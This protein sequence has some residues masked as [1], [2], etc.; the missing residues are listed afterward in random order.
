MSES[1]EIPLHL[2]YED[3]LAQWRERQP[4]C[5][6]R[7]LREQQ[8]NAERFRVISLPADDG[9]LCGVACGLGKFKCELTLYQAAAIA[10]RVPPLQYR[11]A[12]SFSTR[13]GDAIALGFAHAAY[14]F[15]RYRR[16]APALAASIAPIDARQAARVANLAAASKFARDCINTPAAD[17]GPAQL[18]LAA[19]G[20]AE[21]H[22]ASFNDLVGDALLEKNF[23]AVHAVGRASS[24]APRI[25]ELRSPSSAPSEWPLIT[26]V[27]KGVCFDSGG[28]DLKNSAGMLLMKKDM[29][30]AAMALALAQLIWSE[31]LPLRLRVLIPAVENSIGPNA[32]RPGDVLQTR[33]GLSVEVGNT[34][35]EGRLI[36]CDALAAA[37]EEACEAI[38]DFATLTGAARVALGPEIPAL[39]SSDDA[40]AQELQRIALREN[41]PLWHMPLWMGYDDELGSK[42]ADMNNVSPSAFAGA[43][44]GALFLKRFVERTKLW[45]HIDC[46]AWNSRERPGRPVGGEMQG[47]RAVFAFLRERFCPDA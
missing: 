5:V 6:Q 32:Y 25:I 15:D 22:G 35:A 7:W 21:A 18:A 17:F 24:A 10:E 44:F 29:G 45:V 3:A 28:L 13:E 12:Q 23:P 37:D 31:K 26:L 39:F 46:F 33:R 34:D 36:L 19:R 41:D 47:V 38:I 20:L 4:F 16:A 9:A 43:I 14:R 2:I 1:A 11:L 30:G 42:I 40:A 8:W 27:G